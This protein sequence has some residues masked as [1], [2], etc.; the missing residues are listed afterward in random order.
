M[1]QLKSKQPEHVK[2]N[3]GIL[4]D[5]L[6]SFSISFNVEIDEILEIMS[7]QKGSIN[8]QKVRNQLFKKYN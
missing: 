1:D 4:A 3:A 7:K 6:K 5:I 2:S 8:L